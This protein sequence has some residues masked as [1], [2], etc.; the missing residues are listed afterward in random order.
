MELTNVLT[1]SSLDDGFFLAEEAEQALITDLAHRHEWS[2][3]VGNL[4]HR[5]QTLIFSSDH[6][7][8]VEVQ[9]TLVGNP[10]A[11]ANYEVLLAFAPCTLQN[12]VPRSP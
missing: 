4:K 2:R 6:G 10:L 9:F 8:K 12:A 7:L 3:D 5:V 1:L 11:V